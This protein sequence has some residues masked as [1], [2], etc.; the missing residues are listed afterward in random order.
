MLFLKRLNTVFHRL[1]ASYI[2]LV[3]I[4]TVIVGIAS[5][6]YFSMN[7]NR[8][9]EKVN[10][11]M[12]D[13]LQRSMSD[14]I[15]KKVKK[16]YVDITMDFSTKNS[17]HLMFFNDSR[18]GK[19]ADLYNAYSHL[20]EVVAA[21]SD[22]IDSIHIY[23]RDNNML[24]STIAGIKYLDDNNRQDFNS[25]Y[26]LDRMNSEAGRTLWIGNYS[27]ANETIQTGGSEVMVFVRT[28]P[29]NQAG[30]ESKGYIA[31]Y[32][33]KSILENFL[34]QQNSESFGQLI[35]IN[36][37]GEV[38]YGSNPIDFPEE[39]KKEKYIEDILT[40]SNPYGSYIEDVDR[41]KSVVSYI[42]L[43]ETNWRLLN[44]TPVAKFYQQSAFIQRIVILIC[45]ISI[46]VGLVI[47]NI[48]TFNLYN[49]LRSIINNTR[50]LFG[51]MQFADDKPQ[52]EY[53]YIDYVINNLSIKVNDLE[54]TLK[55]N[56]P[57]IK[58]NTVSR[59]LEGTSLPAELEDYDKLLGTK[60]KWPFY[61]AVV[62]EF[63]AEA[64][65]NV[66]LENNQF[67][68]FNVMNQ[69]ENL[70]DSHSLYLAI[71]NSASSIA[72]LVG[73]DSESSENIV[74][75]AGKLVSY[76]FANFMV[77]VTVS[78][79]GCVSMFS[80]LSTSFAQAQYLIKIKYYKPK[81]DIF[82]ADDYN[83]GQQEAGMIPT[84]IIDGFVSA[85]EVRN[86]KGIEQALS[87]FE[88]LAASG[89][90]SLE[91]CHQILIEFTYALVRYMKDKSCNIREVSKEDIYREFLQINNI[92]QF[93]KWL[94]HT[95]T[96]AFEYIE[97]RS[98]G[99]RTDAIKSVQDYITQNLS[100]DLSLDNV[101]NKIFLSPRYLSKVFKEETGINFSDFVT[102]QR[103]KKAAELITTTELSIEQI[104]ASVG[105]SSPA[106]FIK[107]FKEAYGYT[108]KNY[109][110]SAVVRKE[111]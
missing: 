30:T 97:A 26:W 70:S 42:E 36:E 19:H 54:S 77:N 107:K 76:S 91:H 94:F 2:I 38:I 29:L 31:I 24:V 12:L 47:S 58:H 87:E 67:V 75:T 65:K 102:E 15:L 84:E 95:V 32:M 103:V 39:L 100:G 79:G 60:L 101:A 63:D 72:V 49:P 106:Y 18:E 51:N 17:G 68:K 43:E 92:T 50:K 88:S 46:I 22:V 57:V 55:T 40:N 86:L 48:F 41:V 4:T 64:L 110:Y 23:Y 93:H 66:S 62:I 20:K 109:R 52:N 7:F 83:V 14:N 13:H 10:S 45:I 9:V 108:P 25:I 105:Y 81:V 56:K 74:R 85:L 21:N 33:K 98:S 27:T 3:L 44:I 53:K 73:C 28:Y 78:I 59:L 5:Y 96:E 37:D 71:E 82:A 104:A 34:Y 111:P 11:K 90:Y 6:V 99:V 8:E 80:K 16:V 69:I 1:I 35:L 61:R 89:R